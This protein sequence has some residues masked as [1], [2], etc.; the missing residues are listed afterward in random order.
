MGDIERGARETKRRS[1]QPPSHPEGRDKG[2]QSVREAIE[3]L[4]HPQRV[5]GVLRVQLGEL[6]GVAE[7]CVALGVDRPVDV[8]HGQRAEGQ[9]GLAADELVADDALILK[10]H[11][12]DRKREADGLRAARG[13]EVRE[14]E[15]GHG[16]CSAAS[17]A[18]H[19][20]AR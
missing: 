7:N 8:Q 14:L 16:G 3:H 12:A 4:I 6:A 18:Q 15:L 1:L 9:R 20:A 19:T 5:Q 11:A 2:V 17:A 13:R 10:L